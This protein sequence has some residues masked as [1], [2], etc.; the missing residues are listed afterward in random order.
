MDQ[1]D[2]CIGCEK[3]KQTRGYFDYISGFGEPP[4]S[5]CELDTEPQYDDCIRHDYYL[6][7]IEDNLE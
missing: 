7:M 1:F 4:M 3:I 5:Y 6:D 2:I